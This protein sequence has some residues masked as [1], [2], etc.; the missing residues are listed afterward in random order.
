MRRIL[1][2]MMALT[3]VSL[4]NVEVEA[5]TKR[6]NKPAAVDRSRTNAQRRN[7]GTKARP[8]AKGHARTGKKAPAKGAARK[9]T[10]PAHTGKSHANAD[11]AACATNASGISTLA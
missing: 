9:N 10:V 11:A 3:I 4:A 2:L 8:A 7:T 6:N 5:Q 1:M